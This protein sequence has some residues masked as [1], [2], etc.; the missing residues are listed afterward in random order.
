MAQASPQ[1]A[2]AGTKMGSSAMVVG[3]GGGGRMVSNRMLMSQLTVSRSTVMLGS[4]L[5]D[6][7]RGMATVFARPIRFGTA[8]FWL[9]SLRW[10]AAIICS[11]LG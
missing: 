3:G 5:V 9:S 8:R 6:C 11:S 4:G 1:Q 10:F 7:V 2:E